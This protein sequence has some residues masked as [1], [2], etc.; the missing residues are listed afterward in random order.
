MSHWIAPVTLQGREVALE[1]LRPDH[2]DALRAVAADGELWRLWYTTVPRAEDTEAYIATALALAA[3]GSAMPLVVRRLDPDGRP[4][5]VVGCTRYMNIDAKNRRCEI[6]STFYAKSVQRSAVNTETKLL[7]LT[8]AFETLG[9][10]AVE[11]RTHYM[12]QAS[13]AAIARLGAKQDGILRN[14]Q[15]MP[16]GSYRD[17]VVF[18]IV[19]AEW[20]AVRNNLRF[21]LAARSASQD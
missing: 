15:I 3:Q 4:G 8:H 20:P 13:R 16:D 19:A 5:Q 11:F 10:I 18:S 21:K 9:A 1:P 2:A 14:H 12:N 7:L 17:T 6:G